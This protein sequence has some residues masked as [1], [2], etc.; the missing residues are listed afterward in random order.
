MVI[1]L[2]LCNSVKRCVI[3]FG[4][5]VCGGE[6]AVSPERTEHAGDPEDR[7]RH[8]APSVFTHDALCVSSV[9]VPFLSFLFTPYKTNVTQRTTLIML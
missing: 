9:S 1:A 2:V 7:I 4:E 6:P 8:Y 3:D 5:A